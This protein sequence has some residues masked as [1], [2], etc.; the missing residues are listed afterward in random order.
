MVYSRE[1]AAPW[2]GAVSPRVFAD[3][4]EAEGCIREKS[5]SDRRLED[6]VALVPV[7]GT[8]LIG[9]ERIQHAQHFLGI[10]SHVQVVHRDEAD[11]VMGI[12]HK[13]GALRDAFLR[14]EN[15]QV[16]A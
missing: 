6:G 16:R 11:G 5:A 10:A 13:R 4:R 1:T 12:H 8:E 9:L 3:S 7:A 14:I 2:D 15:D